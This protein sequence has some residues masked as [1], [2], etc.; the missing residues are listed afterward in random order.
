MNEELLNVLADIIKKG[1]DREFQN[2]E[3]SHTDLEY[4]KQG[5]PN[6]QL[7][8]SIKALVLAM[9]VNKR[10]KRSRV[11]LKGLKDFE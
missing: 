1:I 5:P 6:D 10:G 2:V 8:V 4:L 3:L 7:I 11:P 9:I